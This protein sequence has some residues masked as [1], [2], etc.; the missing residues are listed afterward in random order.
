MGLVLGGKPESETLFFPCK[1]AVAGDER[2]L[3]CA[4]GA[5]ALN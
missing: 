3:V 1:V 5:A 2:Y 4:A